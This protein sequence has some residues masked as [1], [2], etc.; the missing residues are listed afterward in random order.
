MECLDAPAQALAERLGADGHDHELLKV[1]VI[2]GVRA[3]IQDVHHWRGQQ[4]G[5][6]STEVLIQLDAQVVGHGAGGGHG[7]RQNRVRTQAALGWSSVEGEHS[8]I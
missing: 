1:H 3:T 7:N 2:V 4:A 6:K 5:G 8:V